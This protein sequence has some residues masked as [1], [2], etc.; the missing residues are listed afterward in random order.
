[1]QCTIHDIQEVERILSDDTV[2]FTATDVRE[3]DSVFE[4]AFG[5]LTA[6]GAY[7]LKPENNT[8]FVFKQMNYVL[9][10]MHVG[11]IK[12]S[13]PKGKESAIKAAKWMMNNTTCEKLIAFI[14]EFH[15]P[16]LAYAAECGMVR[17]GICENSFYKKGKLSNTVIM[18]GTKKRLFE[19][20]GEA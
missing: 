8:L 20:Y 5:L 19:L 10:D 13:R 12:G 2:F 17:E 14:P 3:R 9:Y 1:M 7:V 11:I 18:G 16:A 6:P 15:K 4:Y